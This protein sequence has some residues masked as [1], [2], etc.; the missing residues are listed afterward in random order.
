MSLNKLSKTALR[1]LVSQQPYQEPIDSTVMNKVQQIFSL[2]QL[3]TPIQ[4]LMDI[5]TFL[6]PADEVVQDSP[7]EV[8]NQILAQYA[9]AE[10][11]DDS[12][13]ELEIL[14]KV[15]LDEAIRAIQQLHLY[16]EQQAE[17]S[18]TFIH[19]LDKHEQVL[20]SWKLVMQSQRDIRS[21]FGS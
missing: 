14:P 19:E 5:K 15:S 8:D 17:G 2:L 9:P 1:R 20:W 7:N 10:E 13:E 4:D 6:N 21:Y 12:D 11:K 3:S 16:E 18:S